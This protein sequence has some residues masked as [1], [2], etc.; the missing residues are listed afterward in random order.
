M[1]D[2]KKKQDEYVKRH[3]AATMILNKTPKAVSVVFGYGVF[4]HDIT[5]LDEP[6]VIIPSRDGVCEYL[7][8]IGNVYAVH[9]LPKKI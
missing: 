5:Y 8:Y 9:A 3:R 4:P 2:F 1:S 6:I 7:S